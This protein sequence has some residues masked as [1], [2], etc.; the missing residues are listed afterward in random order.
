MCYC[1]S[2][3]SKWEFK[4]ALISN[5]ISSVNYSHKFCF[6]GISVQCAFVCLYKCL[7]IKVIKESFSLFIHSYIF[8]VCVC[9]YFWVWV[10]ER[11]A[12]PRL[13]LAMSRRPES[14]YRCIA[15]LS[16]TSYTPLFLRG[17]IEWVKGKMRKP[18]ER[19]REKEKQWATERE[20]NM[21]DGLKRER[22]V[23]NAMRAS[24][25]NKD[26]EGENVRLTLLDRWVLSRTPATVPRCSSQ[27][28]PH[29]QFFQCTADPYAHVYKHILL[30][31]DPVWF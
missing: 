28:G 3:R 12:L 4:V 18:S 16:R 2:P 30:Q 10:S 22:R 17:E 8:C 23:K 13:D 26:L 27:K 19:V 15:G 6:F 29:R 24:K 20:L 11:D 21:K 25:Q 7:F 1:L 5:P 31:V 9:V 14:N